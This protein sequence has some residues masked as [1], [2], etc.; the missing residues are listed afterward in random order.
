M[1]LKLRPANEVLEPNEL[2]K[3]RI[4]RVK[5]GDIVLIPPYMLKNLFA[6]RHLEIVN[7]LDGV[8]VIADGTLKAKH[9]KKNIYDPGN[10]NALFDKIDDFDEKHPNQLGIVAAICC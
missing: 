3:S 2:S 10:Y 7:R 8:N 6:L 9:W 4:G 1:K 5:N